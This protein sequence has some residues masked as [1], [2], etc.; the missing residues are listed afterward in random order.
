MIYTQPTM[1]LLRSFE[2]KKPRIG[3]GTFLAET[4]TLVGDVVV[5]ARSSIWYGAIL[6]G[7]VFHI[8]VGDEVSIQDLTVIH[9]TSGKFATKVG[10]RVTVGHS[11]VLHGCTVGDSCIIGMGAVIM[12]RATIGKNCIIGAGAL[13]TPGTDIPEGHLAVGSPARAKR[14]LTDKELAWI[15]SSADHYVG[16]ASRYL[17]EEQ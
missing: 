17:A 6:R 5:G 8:E 14:K 1:A 3:D 13:V 10:N 2:K 4:A 15:Q 11:V 16:L 12:D 9:V 7:D